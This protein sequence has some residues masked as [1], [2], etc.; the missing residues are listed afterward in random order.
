[1]N[2]DKKE[3]RKYAAGHCHVKTE[4]VDNYILTIEKSALP[5]AICPSAQIPC[6]TKY[7]R[8]MDRPR[9]GAITIEIDEHSARQ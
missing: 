2:I 6:R 4:A 7:R 3:F 1:M 9:T 5:T 8:C